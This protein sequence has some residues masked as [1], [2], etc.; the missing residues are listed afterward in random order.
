VQVWEYNCF[1]LACV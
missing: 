1:S